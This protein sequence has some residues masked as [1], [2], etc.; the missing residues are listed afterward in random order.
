V[1]PE[2]GDVTTTGTLVRVR[3]LSAPADEKIQVAISQG[4]KTIRSA[5]IVN[6]ARLKIDKVTVVSYEAASTSKPGVLV[7]K[8][9]GTGFPNRLDS[10][11]RKV[12][13]NVTSA[14]EAFLTI[15]SPNATEVVTLTDPVT[16]LSVSTVVARKPPLSQ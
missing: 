13:V 10:S 1:E 16:K 8:I 7:V 3:S 6:P 9:E 11:P 14:T 2:A 5:P 4:N 15:P 12:R